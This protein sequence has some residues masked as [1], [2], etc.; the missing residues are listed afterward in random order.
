MIP[1]RLELS[2]FLAYRAPEPISF[3]GI[4]LACIS[5]N[6]GVGKS[7]LLDAITWALW[8]KARARRE[9]DLIHQGQR[10]MR[11]SLDFLQDGIR[12]RVVRRRARSGRGRRGALDL[13]VWGAD[14]GPRRISAE[15]IRRSQG[16]LNQILRLDYETFV[17]SAFL[18]QGGADAF[19]LKTPAERKR[20]LAEIL[21]LDKWATYED[22]V[23]GDLAKIAQ[24]ISILEHD[25]KR[26]DDEISRESQLREALDGLTASVQEAQAALESISAQYESM[27]NTAALLLREREN[28]TRIERQIASRRADIEAAEAE[29]KRQDERI[30]EY[31]KI[32]ASGDAIEAGYQQ[33]QAA[34]ESQTAIAESLSQQRAL[35]AQVH[36]L[37]RALADQEAKLTGEGDVLKARIEQ[38]EAQLDA[39]E[40]GDLEAVSSELARLENLSARRDEGTAA[41]QTLAARRARLRDRLNQ[42]RSEGQA[43]NERLERL[44]NMDAADGAACPLCGQP[45]TDAHRSETIAQLTDERD[46]KRQVYRDCLE[47]IRRMEDDSLAA[48]KEV[49]EW[50]RQLK[51]LPALQQRMGALNRQI[52]AARVTEND[53]RVL[54]S[55]LAQVESQLEEAAFGGEL[56]RQLKQLEEQRSRI[57]GAG[58]TPADNSAQLD[59]LAAYDRRQKRLEFA[60]INLPEGQA[61]RERAREQWSALCAAQS[62]DERH[63]E[64]NASEIKQLEEQVEQESELRGRLDRARAEV[65]HLRE[66]RT[67]A[68]QELTAVD[69]GRQTRT[70]LQARLTSVLRE[71]SLGKELRM[72][73]GRDGVPGMLIETAIPELE[74][75]ANALLAR[76][77]DGGLR[78]GFRTQRETQGGAVLETLDVTI[79]DSLGARDYEMYSG[80][81]AFRINFAIRIALSK[82]LARR[83][84]AH[85]RTLFIDEGFGSQDATGRAGLVD[86]I[87]KIQADFDLI[88][89]ITHIDELRD[90]FPARL[91][92]EKTADGSTV[93]AS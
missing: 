14:D 49:D 70:R 42:L 81:E 54:R 10:E 90:S 77:T 85:L 8:G 48:Q 57:S 46:A 19:T 32:I 61:M 33:L 44:E 18:Q 12:Y 83:A 20:L 28:R 29:I 17:H 15:G 87:N 35:D 2:N 25:I 76:M 36:K 13:L 22:A 31:Q 79:A 40:S 64:L 92:V 68:Q 69:A 30:A 52:E 86:A 53:L 39:G 78:I 3:D 11:V 51:D 27:A 75:E 84:G 50:A 47:Q 55:Q 65:Q 80:G 23:K 73:F 9:D 4:D 24:E 59:A 16:K 45:L 21:G 88:L 58:T 89:V 1:K 72:A 34:R 37:E 74:A 82:L 43:L 91:L 93:T 6:N 7:S 41:V 38:L 5:G 60:R 66:R 63:L 67:I 56:R 71:Q 62:E 26:A